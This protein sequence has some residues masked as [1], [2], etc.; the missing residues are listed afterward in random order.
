MVTILVPWFI[1][2]RTL[3]LTTE[4]NYF[5]RMTVSLFVGRLG[6]LS[7]SVPHQIR[8]MFWEFR[9]WGLQWWLM[10]AA[11][12]SRPA[13]VIGQPQQL[14]LLDVLG[15]LASLLVAGMLAPAQLDE[16][17]GGSSHR[18]LMQIA[19]VAVLF[20][21]TVFFDERRDQPPSPADVPSTER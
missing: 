16:H 1:H 7:W 19:P 10:V 12:V 18:F 11:L 5:G 13:R 2:R 14:F 15:S 4:M 8:R 3:P 6:T 20:T 17:I 9:D 21:V